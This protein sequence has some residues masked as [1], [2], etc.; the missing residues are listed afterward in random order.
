MPR[1]SM[2]TWNVWTTPRTL[3]SPT[4]CSSTCTICSNVTSLLSRG[5]TQRLG[6]ARQAEAL[7]VL[8]SWGTSAFSLVFP[9]ATGPMVHPVPC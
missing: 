9:L 1:G 3:C 4:P 7:A 8:P 2:Y 6:Y 5:R